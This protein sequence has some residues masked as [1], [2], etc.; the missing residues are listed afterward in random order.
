MIEI[1]KQNAVRYIL[2]LREGGSL[3]A[4][5][6]A[7]DGFRYVLKFKGGGHGS[8]ALISELIGGE[9]ARAAGFHVPEL[10]F[11]NVDSQFGITE[12]DEEIQD[13]LKASPGIN[14]GL[15]FLK[16]ALNLDP[17]ANPVDET[18]ASRIVWLDS[19][20]L[21]VD[22]SFRNTNM[23]EWNKECWLIDHGSSLYFHHNWSDR[24]KAITSPFPYIKT[25]AFIHKA[26]RLAEVD[27][28]M[29]KLITPE[30]ITEIVNLIPEQ[31]LSWDGNTDS[32][33]AIKDEYIRVLTHRRD[34]SGIFVNHAIK[35]H[36]GLV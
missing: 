28:E 35:A 33:Q 7:D 14:L 13:L 10:V 22:R 21:N 11:L 31:W 9:I 32:P 15:H 1:R 24:D 18:L 26:S 27:E 34:N 19:F 20:I 25:H 6:E 3:P 23:L 36:N 29:K 12:P 17:Y 8:K 5:V 2:P 30:K 4:L 16:G